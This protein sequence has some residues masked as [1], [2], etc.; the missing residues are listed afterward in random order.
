MDE[1]QAQ[2]AKQFEVAKVKL[3]HHCHIAFPYQGVF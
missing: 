3:S 1:S 2:A